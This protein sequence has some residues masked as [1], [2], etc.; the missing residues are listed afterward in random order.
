MLALGIFSSAVVGFLIPR[1][2]FPFATRIS[3]FFWMLAVVGVFVAPSRFVERV[4]LSSEGISVRRFESFRVVSVRMAWGELTR[5]RTNWNNRGFWLHLYGADMMKPYIMRL[6]K[7]LLR[8]LEPE[9][10]RM[11]DERKIPMEAAASE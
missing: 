2:S 9:L 6:D 3:A 10:K 1:F 7:D 8:A 4:E 11:C 5:A